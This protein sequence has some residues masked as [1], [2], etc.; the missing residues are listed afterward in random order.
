[1]ADNATASVSCET[2][3]TIPDTCVPHGGSRGSATLMVEQRGEEIVLDV[4]V[5]GGCVIIFEEAGAAA[6]FDVLG[7]WL[8]GVEIG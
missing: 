8:A 1:M 5:S 6:L 2:S 3:R 7:T 4:P